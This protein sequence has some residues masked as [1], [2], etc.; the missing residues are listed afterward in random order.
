MAVR[1]LMTR[2]A[3]VADVSAWRS[4]FHN[5]ATGLE[6]GGVGLSPGEAHEV[7]VAR[8]TEQ[9]PHVDFDI[10]FIDN[11]GLTMRSLRLKI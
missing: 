5:S 2:G 9:L 3:L 4:E 1:S 11:T 8:T 6:G 7:P 10:E